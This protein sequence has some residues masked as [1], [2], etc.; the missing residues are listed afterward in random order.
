MPYLEPIFIQPHDRLQDLNKA[1]LTLLIKLMKLD[2]DLHYTDEYQRSSDVLIDL[3]E[4]F[5]PGNTLTMINGIQKIW[6][7]E[8]VPY[9]NVFGH[10]G[11]LNGSVSCIDLLM[12]TGPQSKAILEQMLSSHQ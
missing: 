11:S 9:I 8:E 6:H 12:N 1:L 10:S 4:A 7:L 5:K 2:I 3:R